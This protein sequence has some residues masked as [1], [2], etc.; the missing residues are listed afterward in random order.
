MFK[1]FLKE[2]KDSFRDRRTLVLTVL[3]PVIMM[4]GLTLFYENMISGDEEKTYTLAVETDI[5]PEEE[6][7][8]SSI[9]NIEMVKVEDIE[10]TLA[11]GDAQAGI[12]FSE[13]FGENVSNGEAATVQI[14]GDSLSQNSASLM[15]LLNNILSEYEKTVIADRLQQEEV[16]IALIQPFTV[17]QFEISED[18]IGLSMLAM[19]IPL[20][21]AIAIGVGSGPSASDLFSGEKEKKTMEALLMSPI[22]RSTLVF[23]KWLAISTIGA[24]TGIVTLIVVSLEIAF[25]TENLKNAVSFGDNAAV[26]IGIGVLITIVYAMFIASLQMVT[27]IIAKTVKESQSYSTPVMMLPVFPVMFVTNIGIN[28]LAFHHFVIPFMNLF[29][30]MKELLFGIVNYEHILLTVGSNIAFMIVF[31]IIGRILFMKDKWVMN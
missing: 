7:I 25:L 10:E 15:S 24:I 22:K 5:A 8:L 23:A 3:L 1:I 21:L 11:E 12:R 26:I 2:M 31:F 14:Y 16:D 4:T 29:S 17:E 13:A 28:E 20:M 19:L 27:S 18:D 6:G 30:L 9:E